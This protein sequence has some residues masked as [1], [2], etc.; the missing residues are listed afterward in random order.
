[1]SPEQIE[2]LTTSN[3]QY[4]YSYLAGGTASIIERWLQTGTK[5]TPQQIAKAIQSLNENTLS[6]FVNLD[7]G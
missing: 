1:M 7:L 3:K 4:V 5:E 2:L 6:L